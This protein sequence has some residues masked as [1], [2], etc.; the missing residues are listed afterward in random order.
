MSKYK[1]GIFR[2][3]RRVGFSILETGKEFAKGKKRTTAPGQHGARRRKLS[4]YGLQQQEKQK[5]R[6]MYGLN[7]KQFR[8]TFL[9]AKKMSG[10]TG[11][12]FLILLESRLDNIVYRLGLARTRRA[13]RQLVNHSHILVNDKKVNIPSYRVSPNDKITIKENY[14]NNPKLLEAIELNAGTLEFVSFDRKN[15][16]GTYLRYSER[17]ELNL[18]INESL[19]VEWYNR[20]I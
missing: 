8:N 20:I 2:I 16:V 11:T 3:S 13:A 7:E 19:I 6:H 5:V 1:R 15:I 4:N 9:K 10:V 14:K 18:E 17:N 12:N